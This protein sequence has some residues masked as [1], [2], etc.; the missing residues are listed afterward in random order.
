MTANKTFFLSLLLATVLCVPFT[1]NAQITIGGGDAPQGFSVLELISNRNMG[2]R[3]PQM[4][5]DERNALIPEL[6]G[7]PK[8]E[9]LLI[10]NTS[11]SCIEGWNGT[12]W[13]SFCDGNSQ[14]TIYPK[15]CQDVPADGDGCEQEFI[16]TDPDCLN[17]PFSFEIIRGRDFA[18]FAFVDEENGMF[19]IFFF[20]N[21]STDSRSVVVRVM[22]DCTLSSKDFLFTQLG[23]ECELAEGSP[24][25]IIPSSN[26]LCRGGAVY[27]SIPDDTP[28]LDNL[29]WTRNRE[30]IFG[31][32]GQYQ[33]IVTQPGNY[34]VSFDFAG[35]GWEGGDVIPVNIQFGENPA[36]ATPQIS[37]LGSGGV[38]C[39]NDASVELVALGNPG[40]TIVWFHNGVLRGDKH[41]TPITLFAP[42]EGEWTAEIRDG[43]C[44]SQR[45]NPVFVRLGA[46]AGQVPLNPA[47]VLVDGQPIET[48][49]SFCSGSD[50]ILR[51][52]NP[53]P[54]ITYRWFNGDVQIASPFRIPAN[55]H[56]MLLR[57]VASDDSDQ[58]C[59]AELSIVE[60]PVTI[61]VTPAAPWITANNFG[62]CP[63][64]TA[65]L[66]AN[67]LAHA[68]EYEWILNNISQGITTDNFF[69][70]NLGTARVRA[71][72]AGGCWSGFSEPVTVY[73]YSVPDIDWSQRATQA[74]ANVAQTFSVQDIGNTPSTGFEWV[75]NPAANAVITGSGFAVS[76]SFT[77]NATVTVTPS[78]NCGDG[79]PISTSVTIVATTLPAPAITTPTPAVAVCNHITFTI[80]RPAAGWTDAQWNGL[81]AGNI[82]A[83]RDNAAVAIENWTRS[84]NTVT[85]QVVASTA[86]TQTVRVNFTGAVAGMNIIPLPADVQG[87][88]RGCCGTGGT[89][90]PQRIGT[91]DYLT[92]YFM[93]NGVMRCWMVENL[94][95]SAPGAQRNPEGASTGAVPKYWT[96]FLGQAEGERGFYYNWRA[97]AL[98]CP[99]GWSTPTRADFNGLATTVNA[100]PDNNNVDNPRRFWWNENALAGW[101]EANGNWLGWGITWAHWYAFDGTRLQTNSTN[102]VMTV[103]N[104]WNQGRGYNVR[105]IQNP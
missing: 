26:Q 45:S 89:A 51:I 31:S 99:A 19:S 96:T 86:A 60:V 53:Q 16:I 95:E 88:V 87:L 72:A 12:R 29:I 25:I 103:S 1:A 79:V 90:L 33:I 71:R 18:D 37:A 20:P 62:I 97:A 14:M 44:F 47:D 38:I 65:R 101:R 63:G 17:G 7:N 92:H 9:G 42:D 54:G 66:I 2:L 10:F 98:A 57:M 15:P 104:T 64:S 69:D 39:G 28:G 70:S 22:S 48:I 105:C 36:P 3:L 52:N 67:T 82:R 43:D 5:T 6:E 73:G 27:L 40:G 102:R 21:N 35:C 84:G 58:L 80:I 75:V 49:T 8:A 11:N 91:R 74:Q 13:V 30:E 4:T 85:F 34:S 41:G 50:I 61:D 83:T 24:P 100:M 55:Q 23:R 46:H 94:R 77:D 56:S 81:A 32:R 59:P 78:N 76:I 68:D 93:T